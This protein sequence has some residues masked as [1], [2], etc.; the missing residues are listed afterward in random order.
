[1]PKLLVF[2]CTSNE[3]S[4]Q[5]VSLREL[6]LIISKSFYL[7]KSAVHFQRYNLYNVVPNKHVY[8]MTE[9]QN[10][11]LNMT[12]K[13][14][15]IK[16]DHECEGGVEKPVPSITVWRLEACRVMTNGDREGRIFL[17]QS[18]LILA[19]HYISHF[20]FLKKAPRSSW[21]SWDAT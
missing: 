18:I 19:H 21:I 10:K 11:Q 12:W 17:S 13:R 1:M 15:D 2:E 3:L 5:L 14:S 6:M 8:C 16:I 4:K 9:T 7:I 20:H